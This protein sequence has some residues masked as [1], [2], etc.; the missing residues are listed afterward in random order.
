MSDPV[1]RARGGTAC[2]VTQMLLSR[3]V[4]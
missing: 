2:T 4:D 1:H 3:A